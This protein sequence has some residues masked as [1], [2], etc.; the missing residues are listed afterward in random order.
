MSVFLCNLSDLVEDKWMTFTAADGDE[1]DTYMVKKQGESIYVYRNFCPHQGRRLDY[2]PGEFL[3][4]PDKQ[5][6]CPA[7]GAT[8]KTED[9]FCTGGPCA[10][11]SLKAIAVTTRDNKLY[12]DAN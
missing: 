12:I 9:G 7:H 10:G 11:D 8:F 5:V 3:E 6:V 2:A 1:E 4:T